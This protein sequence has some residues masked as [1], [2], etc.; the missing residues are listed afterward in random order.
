MGVDFGLKRVGLA[1]CDADRILATPLPV[2]KT[3]TMRDT[4]DRVAAVANE[5]GAR[6]IVIGLPLNLDGTESE[7]SGRVRAF[8]RN[9]ERVTGLPA[10]LIDERLTTVEANELLTEAGVKRKTERDKLIDSMS[11]TVILQSFLEK[12]KTESKIMAEEQNNAE[13]IDDEV[14]TL[15]DDDNNPVDFNEEA[16]V[17]YEGD[18]YA[19]LT[20]VKPMEG[21]AED[22]ALIFKI[23]EEDEETDAF[24][25]VTDERTLDAVFNEYLKCVADAE[26]DCCGGECDCDHDCDG[27]CDHDGECDRDGCSEKCGCEHHKHD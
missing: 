6:G 13:L 17:E 2:Y 22:E 20:P 21:L 18:F 12:D 9:L 16:V 8:A 11:A 26:C 25:P 7:A 24:E 4:I 1:V 27:K 15:Y 3:T 10:A 14:I 23:I 19:L 5:R